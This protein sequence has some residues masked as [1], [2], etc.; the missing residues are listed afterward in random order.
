MHY[1]Q[2]IGCITVCP[3][4]IQIRLRYTE[5]PSFSRY[6]RRIVSDRIKCNI[7]FTPCRVEFILGKHE[8]YLYFQSFLIAGLAQIVEIA[9]HRKHEPTSNSR[10]MLWFL[11]QHSDA[12]ASAVVVLVSFTRNISISASRKSF[13]YARHVMLWILHPVL[14]RWFQLIMIVLAPR[15]INGCLRDRCPC[16]L[17]LL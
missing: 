3:K 2:R 11:M 9:L 16:S 10:P 7:S 1:L 15:T 12:T 8:I 5:F 13:C 4:R 17:V 6:G 14:W